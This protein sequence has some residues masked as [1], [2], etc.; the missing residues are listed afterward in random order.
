MKVK[1]K[2]KEET[3][4]EKRNTAISIFALVTL[5]PLLLSLFLGFSMGKADEVNKNILLKELDSLREANNSLKE[6][7]RRI[8][9]IFTD[10]DTLRLS[11]NDDMEKLESELKAIKDDEDDLLLRKWKRKQSQKTENYDEEFIDAKTKKIKNPL[12]IPIYQTCIRWIEDVVATKEDELFAWTLKQKQDIGTDIIS[13]LEKRIQD[14]EG[15]LLI[16]ETMIITMQ[17]SLGQNQGS[18]QIQ[19]DNSAKDVKAI[20][21]KYNN[22]IVGNLGIKDIINDEIKAINQDVFPKLKWGLFNKNEF[23]ELKSLLVA[24]IDGIQSELNKLKTEK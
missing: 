7:V 21:D 24:K 17:A 23:N 5:I 8:G 19:L 11:F 6:D 2:Q 1:K 20:Q 13:D 16:K 15:D 22:L 18:T 10:I 12:L 4:F 3:A 14:L 9:K